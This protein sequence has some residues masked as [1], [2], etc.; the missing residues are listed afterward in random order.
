MLGGGS[1]PCL[2]APSPGGCSGSCSGADGVAG[3]E[4]DG[5]LSTHANDQK[6]QRAEGGAGAGVSGGMT[7]GQGDHGMDDGVSSIVDD[8]VNDVVDVDVLTGGENEGETKLHSIGFEL[9]A[10]MLSL[11]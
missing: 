8:G 3:C 6:A 9:A 5:V 7:N 4:L 11:W 1:S 10:G 2:G